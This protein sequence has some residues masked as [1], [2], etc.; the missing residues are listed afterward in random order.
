MPKAHIY[1]LAAILIAGVQGC[2]GGSSGSNSQQATSG[3]STA[4]P[5]PSVV[6]TPVITPTLTPEPTLSTSPTPTPTQTPP[7]PNSE[8][9]YTTVFTESLAADVNGKNAYE[10]V[11]EKFGRNA[12]EAP[13]VYSSNHQ[14][15]QHLNQQTD[16]IV[17]DHFVFT[18]HLQNDG[19]KGNFVD[20]QRNEIKVYNSSIDALKGFEG[21]TFEYTWKFKVNEQMELSKKFSHFFQLK[22]VYGDDAQ[23]IIT[24]SGSER[25]S[26]DSLQIRYSPHTTPSDTQY[27]A[28][29]DWDEIKG[30]W[31]SAFC[32]VTFAEAS[33]GGMIQMSV[34]RMR[35]DTEMLAINETN[36][37]MWRGS[38]NDSE[39]GRTPFVRPKWGY[40]RSYADAQNLRDDE[41]E[42]RFAD[43]VIKE[44]RPADAN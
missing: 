11:R 22:A 26:E 35:D 5:T 8:I 21:K 34:T 36:I 12:I 16:S 18:L 28:F 40:Y 42:I 44:V 43:F 4:T 41:E 9:I 32:R 17:G 15:V 23:P 30:E 13:D 27:L 31:L 33:E 7:P 6:A 24:I 19:D 25:S 14:A 39:I 38:V 37:D 2:S 1:C 10:L 20:R 3:S 29:A